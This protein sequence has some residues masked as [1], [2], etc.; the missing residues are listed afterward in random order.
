MRIFVVVDRIFF[1]TSTALTSLSLFS[2]VARFEFLSFGSL[3]EL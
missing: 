3:S 1:L 2:H